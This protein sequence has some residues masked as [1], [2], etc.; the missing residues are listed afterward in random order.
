VKRKRPLAASASAA[1]SGRCGIYEYMWLLAFVA[2]RVFA[3]P[4]WY[5]ALSS[6]SAAALRT[7]FS[8]QA[9][10]PRSGSSRVALTV[11]G[12]GAPGTYGVHYALYLNAWSSRL[13]S[14]GW[15][16]QV[17]ATLDEQMHA[18]A[19]SLG[20]CAVPFFLERREGNR[21]V[22]IDE[23]RNASDAVHRIPPLVGVAKFLLLTQLLRRGFAQYGFTLPWVP[24][25][26]S[27]PAAY[28]PAANA[29]P[30]LPLPTR[31]LLPTP[32]CLRSRCSHTR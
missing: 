9:A 27:R 4:D 13:K 20:I 17:I 29:V 26:E 1:S 15:E 7:C 11:A 24:I 2:T 28:A 23:S 25:L 14:F 6:R 19:A 31:C 5:T 10:T 21:A 32:L 8:D 22:A 30:T 12:S 16:T 18:Q 3:P